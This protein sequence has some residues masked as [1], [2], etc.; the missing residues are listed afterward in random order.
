MTVM[1]DRVAEKNQFFGKKHTRETIEK[2]AHT[3][4]VSPLTIRGEKSPLWKG[5]VTEINKKI[6][7]SAKI[8]KWRRDVFHRDDYTCQICGVRGCE[9]QADHIKPFSLFPKERFEL[10]NG[11]TLCVP[12]H[13]QTPTYLGKIKTYEK[14][15]LKI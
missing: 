2:I 4:T 9:L 10:S 13:K 5:G 14:K 11:R 3:K 6:R 12:C 7:S 1:K 15:L 8:K